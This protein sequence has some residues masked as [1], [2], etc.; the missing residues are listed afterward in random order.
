M[1]ELEMEWSTGRIFWMRHIIESVRFPLWRAPIH[2]LNAYC[3][4]KGKDLVSSAVRLIRVRSARTGDYPRLLFKTRLNMYWCARR[5]GNRTIS[6]MLWLWHSVQN[7]HSLDAK[8]S[9]IIRMSFW[10]S[11]FRIFLS[12]TTGVIYVCDS[13]FRPNFERITEV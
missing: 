2:N 1:E 8:Y 4:I 11:I 13:E 7:I 12:H 5:R 6:S 9:V 3:I 10:N